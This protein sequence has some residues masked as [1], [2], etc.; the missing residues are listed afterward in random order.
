MVVPEPALMAQ[1]SL[2]VV[3][4]IVNG[5][6]RIVYNFQESGLAYP[7]NSLLSGRGRHFYGT[8]PTGGGAIFKI[9]P[10]GTLSTLYQFK[11]IIRGRPTRGGLIQAADGNFYGTTEYGGASSAFCPSGCGTVFKL[12][13]K[14]V[15]STVYSF[16]PQ[17][18]CPDGGVYPACGS[19]GSGC[20]R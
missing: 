7:G 11:W 15:L 16:C 6:L 2:R 18:Y 8:A 20:G 19:V 5:K 13:P 12:T 3:F 10:G 1:A 4:T 9:T 17:N 14:G